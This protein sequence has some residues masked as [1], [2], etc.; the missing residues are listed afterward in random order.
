[1]LD[2]LEAAY[3]ACS[4]TLFSAQGHSYLVNQQTRHIESVKNQLSRAI[5]LAD[6]YIDW[7][8][9]SLTDERLLITYNPRNTGAATAHK[10]STG[11]LSHIANYKLCVVNCRLPRAWNLISMCRA[12]DAVLVQ[13]TSSIIA[14]CRQQRQD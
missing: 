11:C 10:S 14:P 2:L 6:S 13:L 9:V 1:M 12:K 3:L 8:S 7:Y 5:P 4:C